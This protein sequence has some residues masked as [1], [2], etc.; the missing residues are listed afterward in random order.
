MNNVRNETSKTCVSQSNFRTITTFGL[1]AGQVWHFVK[2]QVGGSLD[3]IYVFT[4]VYP[5]RVGLHAEI[6]CFRC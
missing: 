4:V 5:I 3:S 6:P 2:R 1:P